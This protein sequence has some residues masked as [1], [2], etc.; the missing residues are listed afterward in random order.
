MI[1]RFDQPEKF[2]PNP[3]AQ[4]Q[5]RYFSALCPSEMYGFSLSLSVTICTL[6]IIWLLQG[7]VEITYVSCLGHCLT[8]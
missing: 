5:L 7:L 3:L 1:L 8:Q 2:R 6:G 4:P